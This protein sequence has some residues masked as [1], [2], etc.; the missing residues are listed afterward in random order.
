MTALSDRARP[1]PKIVAYASEVFHKNRHCVS[2][3]MKHAA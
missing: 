1:I 2:F 3:H